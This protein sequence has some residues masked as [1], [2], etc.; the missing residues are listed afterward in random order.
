MPLISLVVADCSSSL[1]LEYGIKPTVIMS[2][3]EVGRL[4][5]CNPIL[6]IEQ[7]RDWVC[8]G[9]V[10]THSYVRM[11]RGTLKYGCSFDERLLTML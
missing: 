9:G 11:V 7:Y 1:S 6:Y 10:L 2:D 3:V 8:Y 5:P 4:V